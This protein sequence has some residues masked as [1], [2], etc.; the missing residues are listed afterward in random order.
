MNHSTEAKPPVGWMLLCEKLKLK[1]DHGTRSKYSEMS[2]LNCEDCLER[3]WISTS[4]QY[5]DFE[6]GM[7]GLSKFS[8]NLRKF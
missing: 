1:V 4:I 5:P 6:V 8:I 7:F 3:L 2:K